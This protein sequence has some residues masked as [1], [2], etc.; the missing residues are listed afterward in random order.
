VLLN[1]T[2]RDEKG[3]FVS[4]LRENDFQVFEDGVRQTVKSFSAG[5]APV[6]AG[7]V[8]DH[9][10]SMR[11]KILDVIAG[12]EAFARHSNPQDEIFVV[13]FNEKVSTGLN[14]GFI[15]TNSPVELNR[16]ILSAPPRG[17]TALYDAIATGIDQL[18]SGSRE[19]KVLIVISDGGDNASSRSLAG[20]LRL[21]AES[22]AIIYCIGVFDEKDRD[23]NPGVLRQIARST[24]GAVFLP[25]KTAD[26]VEICEQ[27]AAEIRNQYTIG[28]TP[29]HGRDGAYHK[30]R[31][32]AQAAGRGKVS[33][34]A[35]SGYIAE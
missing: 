26:V 14:G 7:L 31:V 28:Y 1:A 13:N 12:A 32:G 24:G 18:K 35:R 19:K 15:F 9:S 17:M 16:A 3:R 22:S 20:V 33:V 2:V 5:D 8:V 11:E 6:T 25:K 30:L 23:R 10:G 27:I 34:R 4:G 21:A 29:P